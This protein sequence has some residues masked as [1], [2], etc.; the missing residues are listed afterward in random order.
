[1]R[2]WDRVVPKFS[3][4]F[5]KQMSACALWWLHLFRKK[6]EQTSHFAEGLDPTGYCYLGKLPVLLLRSVAQVVSDSL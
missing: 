6:K 3:F 4:A 2:L 5:L 1:M